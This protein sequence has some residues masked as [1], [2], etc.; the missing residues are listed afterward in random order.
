M[1]LC[2]AA[3]ALISLAASTAKAATSY[4]VAAHVGTT[5]VKHYGHHGY[6]GHRGHH[7]HRSY[8]H[9]FHHPHRYHGHS[10][11]IVHPRVIAHP[12]V[13][14]YRTYHTYPVHPHYYRSRGGIS[15]YGRGFGISIGF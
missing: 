4:P 7:G 13:Y 2:L 5:L 14:H 9:G 3:L 11:V 15:Y 8:H 12:P 6:H 1:A 10:R